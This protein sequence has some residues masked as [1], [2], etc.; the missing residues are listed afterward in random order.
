MK[1]Y[2]HV[3]TSQKT[4]FGSS[5]HFEH[6]TNLEYKTCE[7]IM[8]T[9]ENIHMYQLVS[10]LWWT[11]S[12][13]IDLDGLNGLGPALSTLEMLIAAKNS[14]MLLTWWLL[15]LPSI[16]VCDRTTR[17]RTRILF[18]VFLLLPIPE[19]TPNSF[20]QLHMCLP[21]SLSLLTHTPCYRLL[22]HSLL[23][24]SISNFHSNNF[25]TFVCRYWHA[26]MFP[27]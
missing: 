21:F 5:N 26:H 2:V 7:P 12:I 19:W 17:E 25:M 15:A 13:L 27:F 16:C 1:D 6:V 10:Q 20:L 3:F 18:L 22:G 11:M 9:T 4:M 23:F 8:I 24:V 14:N